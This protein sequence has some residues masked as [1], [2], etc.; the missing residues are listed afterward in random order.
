M[1][2]DVGWKSNKRRFSTLKKNKTH[3][4]HD[5]VEEKKISLLSQYYKLT[6]FSTFLSYQTIQVRASLFNKHILD[7]KKIADK[8]SHFLQYNILPGTHGVIPYTGYERFLNTIVIFF[9]CILIFLQS[10]AHS[11]QSLFLLKNKIILRNK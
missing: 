7:K 2:Q 10:R 6:T 4:V 5:L 1:L 8:L 9:V 3:S 11:G